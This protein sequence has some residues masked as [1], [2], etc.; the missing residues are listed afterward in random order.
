MITTKTL[1]SFVSQPSPSR[2][3]SLFHQ[4]IHRSYILPVSEQCRYSF[5]PFTFFAYSVPRLPAFPPPWFSKTLDSLSLPVSPLHPI[6]SQVLTQSCHPTSLS[7]KYSHYPLLVIITFHILTHFFTRSTFFSISSLLW[8][9]STR[10]SVSPV[11]IPSTFTPG[12]LCVPPLPSL[13]ISLK[14]YWYNHSALR[15]SCHSPSLSQ[16]YGSA[17]HSLSLLC[18]HLPIIEF[19]F[20]FLGYVQPRHGDITLFGAED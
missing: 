20:F 7:S 10:V 4:M 5:D 12:D 15:L 3:P 13:H 11:V 18:S 1:S 2:T 19:N 6:L 17:T 9:I 14:R 8:F 16:V